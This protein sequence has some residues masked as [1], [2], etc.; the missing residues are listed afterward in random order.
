MFQTKVVE[1][2]KTHVL[3]SATFFSENHAFYERMW[4][5][6]VEPDRATEDNIIRRMRVACWITKATDGHSEYAIL[7]AFLRQQ[8]LRERASI[9]CL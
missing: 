2:I 5:N 6:V 9:L 3:L 7:I 4:K 1:K 8:W